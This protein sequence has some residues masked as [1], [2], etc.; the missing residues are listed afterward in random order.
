[1]LEV[2]VELFLWK[3]IR[4]QQCFVLDCYNNIVTISTTVVL[5]SPVKS[6]NQR[7]IFKEE[8]KKK[9]SL[10]RPNQQEPVLGVERKGIK[11]EILNMKL[12]CVFLRVWKST[13]QKRRKIKTY[14]ES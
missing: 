3:N 7:Y 9:I 14:F 11:G 5:L 10:E 13:D 4:S 2:I 1:M 12:N 8:T 6:A